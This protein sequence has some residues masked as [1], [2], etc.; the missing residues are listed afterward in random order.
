MLVC[1]KRGMDFS[2]IQGKVEKTSNE[3]YSSKVLLEKEESRPSCFWWVE[4]R[5]KI[6][7]I[8]RR[9]WVCLVGDV[10]FQMLLLAVTYM[11][12]CSAT[13][14]SL[15]RHHITSSIT[16][17]QNYT[18]QWSTF[19]LTALD[20]ISILLKNYTLRLAVMHDLRMMKD[21]EC[22]QL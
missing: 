6:E 20:T 2:S 13:L 17:W 3:H 4:K 19:G 8:L 10:S 7:W 5:V 14:N 22:I 15:M 16:M 11:P 18:A 21:L 12:S 1:L 9:D